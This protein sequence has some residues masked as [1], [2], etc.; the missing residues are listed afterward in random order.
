MSVII[1]ILEVNRDYSNDDACG[2][3]PVSSYKYMPSA[4]EVYAQIVKINNIAHE[5]IRLGIHYRFVK[6]PYSSEYI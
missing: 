4:N 5:N 2:F 6:L 1:Y 3:E